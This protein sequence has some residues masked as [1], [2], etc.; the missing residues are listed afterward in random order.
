MGTAWD[1]WNRDDEMNGWVR[2]IS[3][4]FREDLKTSEA[5]NPEKVE[6]FKALIEEGSADALRAAAL[7]LHSEV[8]V[9]DEYAELLRALDVERVGHLRDMLWDEGQED[10]HDASIAL[11]FV[12][13]LKALDV[14]LE[15]LEGG[16][17]TVRAQTMNVLTLK[18][19][20]RIEEAALR[21][22]KDENCFVREYALLALCRCGEE[23][24]RDILRSSMDDDPWDRAKVN[25]AAAL[26][27]LGDVVAIDMLQS[28]AADCDDSEARME[29]A[30]VLA[31]IGDKDA[32]EMLY[33]FANSEESSQERTT[34]RGKL[35]AL[36]LR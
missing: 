13:D 2:D 25:A 36:G 7:S 18:W 31:S 28:I 12:D 5:I 16:D 26:A 14:L 24:H 22:V 9:F 4:F 11:A 27:H 15:A 29:A 21:H 19:G 3:S 33:R 17:E 32:L 8:K 23:K 34:A 35:R 20:P 30:G 6:Q 1:T 10:R